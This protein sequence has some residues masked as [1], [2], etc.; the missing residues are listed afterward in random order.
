MICK[1]A[2]GCRVATTAGGDIG[3]TSHMK[4]RA[5]GEEY[6]LNLYSPQV[7]S[8]IFDNLKAI[9]AFHYEDKQ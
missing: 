1:N 8:F 2:D 9:I 6:Y 3:I 4:T 5:N 7:Q